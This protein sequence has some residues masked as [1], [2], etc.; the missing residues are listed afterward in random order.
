MCFGNLSPIA[1][2]ISTSD[3]PTRSWATANPPRSGTVSRSQTM[4]LGFMQIAAYY[5]W[6]S[7]VETLASYDYFICDVQLPLRVSKAILR[8]LLRGRGSDVMQQANGF[9]ALS[10]LMLRRFH[11]THWTIGRVVSHRIC[12]RG[13]GSTTGCPSWAG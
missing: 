9:F 2:R 13:Y 11:V 6:R 5:R 3:L 4:T 7:C 1:S 10:P 8:N 12:G